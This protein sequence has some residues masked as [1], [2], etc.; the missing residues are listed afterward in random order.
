MPS[1]WVSTTGPVPVFRICCWHN[2]DSLV[3]AVVGGLGRCFSQG[4]GVNCQYFGVLLHVQLPAT[5][6]PFF[7]FR[8]AQ[9]ARSYL[10]LINCHNAVLV[11]CVYCCAA[12]LLITTIP[13]YPAASCLTMVDDGRAGSLVG[14][15]ARPAALGW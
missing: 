1:N 2:V 3:L 11:V 6:I 9:K 5:L 12:P 15:W 8:L 7:N 13:P 4:S 10:L 14:D